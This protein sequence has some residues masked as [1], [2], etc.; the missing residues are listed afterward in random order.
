MI[1]KL[2][3]IFSALSI[4]GCKDGA[5]KLSNTSS[6]IQEHCYEIKGDYVYMNFYNNTDEVLQIP[7]ITSIVDKDFYLLEDYYK[8]KN[9]TLFMIMPNKNHIG[10]S[11]K[12]ENT[13]IEVKNEE[14]KL[15]KGKKTQQLFKLKESF[16]YI[17]LDNK[18]AL[19]SCN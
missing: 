3:L 15:E 13:K 8:I 1:L 7:K 4:V 9:D 19:N 6:V 12:D 10:V 16:K 5:N 18:N 2:I 11:H 14:I 17:I